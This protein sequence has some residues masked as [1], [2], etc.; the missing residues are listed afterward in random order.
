MGETITFDKKVRRY[1]HITVAEW[2]NSVSVE[3]LSLLEFD[4]IT[5]GGRY[6]D[7]ASIVKRYPKTLNSQFRW[8]LVSG[9]EAYERFLGQLY[10]VLGYCDRNLWRCMD[11]GNDYMV[12]QISSMT[13]G[14]FQKRVKESPEIHPV[15]IRSLIGHRFGRIQSAE[16][17]NSI[18]FESEIITYKEYVNLIEIMRHIIVH[19]N[20]VV[21]PKDLFSRIEKK[22]KRRGPLTPKLKTWILHNDFKKFGASFE[23][24]LVANSSA[25]VHDVHARPLGSLIQRLGS[26]AC[27]LYRETAKH[28]GH[29]PF[30]V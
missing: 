19:E 4:H 3:D 12:N 23:V 30:W 17:K 29:K 15:K 26:H 14:D 9:Y 16:S 2:F 13:L 5:L 27:L 20:S 7:R 11:F 18:I 24:W 21:E 6:G 22:W 8:L 25:P 28:F 10:A 1:E